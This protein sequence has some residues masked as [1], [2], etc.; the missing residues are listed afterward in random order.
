VISALATGDSVTVGVVIARATD[1]RLEKL[2]SDPGLAYLYWLLTRLTWHSRGEDFLNAL[3]DEGIELGDRVDGLQFLGR[4]SQ[5]AER[6]IRKRSVPNALSYIALRAFSETVNREVLQRA[7]TLFGVSGQD[8]QRAFR[9]LSTKTNFAKL[10]RGF[11]GNLLGGILQFIAS[12][13]TS[14]Y[15]GPTKSFTNPRAAADF[16][17]ELSAYA[18]QCTR[19]L[20]DFSGDWYSKHNWQ[21]D[22][23]ERQS[24]RFVAY[25]LEKLRSELKASGGGM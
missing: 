3:R 5:T 8:V 23:D 4:I 9:E 18:Y 17:G 7:D 2:G 11:F 6:G 15:V 14:N 16:E 10:A 1:D 19:I 21:G 22:I 24:G 25:A 20:E 13:E 12:K